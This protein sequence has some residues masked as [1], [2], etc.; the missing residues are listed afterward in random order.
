MKTL[1]A[2][3][4]THLD[5]GTTTMC[6]CW[7]L[8]RADAVV[9]GFT[10]HDR[11]LVIGG[12][13]YEAA[14][15]FTA[16]ELK[17]TAGL[18]VDN[19][20]VDGALSSETLA[21]SDLAAGIYDDAAVEIWRV[22]WADTAQRVLMRKGSIGEV[23]RGQHAFTAEIRGLA[24]YL[25]QE[26]GRTYQFTCDAEFGDARCGK[27]LADAA[28][29]GSGA[30]TAVSGKLGIKVS[31]LGAFTDGWF[32]GGLLTWTS[33][34]NAGR[35]VEI[36][37]HSLA[38]S[39]VGLQLWHSMAGAVAVGDGFTITAGCNKLFSTCRDTFANSVNFRG[40]P[41]MPG[42]DWMIGYVKEG[43]V[44]AGQVLVS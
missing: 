13:T 42:N 6:W 36:R 30:V 14:T 23:K 33:G 18:N 44:Y 31:D 35:T 21:E 25:N 16:S 8:T 9:L 11:D 5:S 26:H 28:Y 10:D 24:H 7:K 12:V 38:A 41:H 15:G 19:L 2:G 43:K 39:G 20:D 37:W 17:D 34:A 29:H 1:P 22:N 27:N 40:C 32:T 3:L 4:Q